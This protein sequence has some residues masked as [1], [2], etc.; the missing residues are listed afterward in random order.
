MGLRVLWCRVLRVFGGFLL[1]G[2]ADLI[3]LLRGILT[4]IYKGIIHKGRPR[5]LRKQ[6][7][8]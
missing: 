2:V 1:G 4:G 7:Y 3:S 8:K 6:V 5:G